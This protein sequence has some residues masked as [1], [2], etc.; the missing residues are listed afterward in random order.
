MYNREE[1]SIES[2]LKC[3]KPSGRCALHSLETTNNSSILNFQP[4]NSSTSSQAQQY[5]FGLN[6]WTFVWNVI[7]NRKLAEQTLIINCSKLL[8]YVEKYLRKHKYIRKKRF[9]LML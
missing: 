8:T 9:P 3:K 5:Q 6:D 1:Y 4:S 2:V 7:K